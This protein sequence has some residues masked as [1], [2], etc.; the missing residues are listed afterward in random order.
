MRVAPAAAFRT[1][2]AGAV[3]IALLGDQ[4]MIWLGYAGLSGAIVFSVALVALVMGMPSAM[5]VRLA[6]E[7]AVLLL[8]AA[9]MASVFFNVLR[10]RRH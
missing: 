2:S 9:M 7:T 1:I 5:I 10:R 8:G 6:I 4:P 3:A